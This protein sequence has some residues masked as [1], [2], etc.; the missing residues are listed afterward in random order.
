MAYKQPS[1]GLPF[2]QLGSSPAKQKRAKRVKKDETIKTIEIPKEHIV[3]GKKNPF[4]GP[5]LKSPSEGGPMPGTGMIWD[6]AEQKKFHQ[7]FKAAP[8]KQRLK[9]DKPGTVVS[10]TAKKVGKVIKS[11]A[12]EI[13]RQYR[14]EGVFTQKGRD[15]KKDQRLAAK[16]RKLEKKKEL[17]EVRKKYR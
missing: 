10:R 5:V 16:G 7:T 8:T 13:G 3:E 9:V 6:A 17:H 11:S 15:Y 14:D 12:K 1:S 2:K 4:G